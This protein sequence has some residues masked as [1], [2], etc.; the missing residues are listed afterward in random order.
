[1]KE[2]GSLTGFTVRV[3]VSKAVRAPSDTVTVIVLVPTRSSA[4]VMVTVRFVPLPPNTIEV[5]GIRLVFDEPFKRVKNCG[6]VS[7]SLMVNSIGL[8]VVSSFVNRFVMFEIV[9]GSLRLLI[10]IF[11]VASESA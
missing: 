6:S 10:V 4:G 7:G 1:M 3:K 11:T 8:V 2:G 5:S 9:G